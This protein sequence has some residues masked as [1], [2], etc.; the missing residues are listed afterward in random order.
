[1]FQLQGCISEPEFG[2]TAKMEVYTNPS[3][4]IPPSWDDMGNIADIPKL[5]EIGGKGYK[6]RKFYEF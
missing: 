5:S 6:W 2:Y 4:G 3:L 1:M